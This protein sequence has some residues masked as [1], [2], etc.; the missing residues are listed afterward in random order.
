[1]HKDLAMSAEKE[2]GW[3]CEKTEEL[4]GDYLDGLLQGDDRAAFDLHV[5][6]CER[7]APLVASVTSLV[8][9]LH[10]MEQLPEPPR[11]VYAILDKTLGPRD[12]GSAWDAFL[13]W[14]RG[15]STIRLAYGALSVAATLMIFVTASG[16]NWRHPKVADLQPANVYRNADRQAH[17]VYARGTKFV[18]DLRV[19]YEIQSRLRQDSEI[20]TSH[21]GTVPAPSPEKQ[22]GRSDGSQPSAPKQQNRAN[23]ITGEIE[24]LATELPVFVGVPGRKLP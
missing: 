6:G 9:N 1:V 11:L 24:L 22:P 19:V 17:L 16:F 21:E 18:S 2:M 4:L 15:L 5:N 13:A 14:G 10:S 12:Q 7:C 20:P 8:S 3:S 23:G